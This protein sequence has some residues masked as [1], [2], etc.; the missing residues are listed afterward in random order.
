MMKTMVAAIVMATTGARRPA[1]VCAKGKGCAQH[2]EGG[3]EVGERAHPQPVPPTASPT[4][5]AGTRVRPCGQTL[6]PWPPRP[7]T[8]LTSLSF[9]RP[10][11]RPRLLLAPPG[12]NLSAPS[13][14]N[15]PASLPLCPAWCTAPCPNF[16]AP[17]SGRPPPVWDTSPAAALATHLCRPFRSPVG[18]WMGVRTCRWSGSLPPP[19]YPSGASPSLAADA[20]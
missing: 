18:A 14:P 5:L 4:Q 8:F 3:L 20:T 6:P 12:P 13:R 16:R 11:A 9:L 15:L 7:A 2:R 10:G 19:L 17:G 1:L